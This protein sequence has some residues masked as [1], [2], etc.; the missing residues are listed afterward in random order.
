MGTWLMRY[1]FDQLD[2]LAGYASGMPS[3]AYYDR[4]WHKTVSARPCCS[5]DALAAEVIVEI[6]RLARERELAD[7]R[8]RRRMPSPPCR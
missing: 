4:L 3:P 8:F 2:A 5:G 7:D 1:S 6:G